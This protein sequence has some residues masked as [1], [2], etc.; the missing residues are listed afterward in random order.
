MPIS[1]KL[2]LQV[3][4]FMKLMKVVLESSLILLLAKPLTND[5]VVEL[6]HVT[7]GEN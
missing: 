4:D 3:Q 2:K 6:D 1:Y 7:N 5:H